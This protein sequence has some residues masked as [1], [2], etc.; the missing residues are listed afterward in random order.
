M[1]TRGND[2]KYR[3]ARGVCHR[4]LLWPVALAGC[5]EEPGDGARSRARLKKVGLGKGAFLASCRNPRS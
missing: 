5:T 3:P 4:L 2:V 1:L